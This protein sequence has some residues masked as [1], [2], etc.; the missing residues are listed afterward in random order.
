[1]LINRKTRTCLHPLAA[2]PLNMFYVTN[3]DEITDFRCHVVYCLEVLSDITPSIKP[4]T[5]NSRSS[6]TTISNR[7]K[8]HAIRIEFNFLLCIT[9]GIRLITFCLFTPKA[10]PIPFL[11]SDCSWSEIDTVSK[12][13]HLR[14]RTCSAESYTD[15]TP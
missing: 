9:A 6:F 4:F 7:F 8:I 1:M 2:P 12:K 13:S 3:A 14:Q 5:R 10:M 11:T 15:Q